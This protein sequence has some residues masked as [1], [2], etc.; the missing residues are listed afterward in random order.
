LRKQF[1]KKLVSQ[2]RVRIRITTLV[3]RSRDIKIK[4]NVEREISFNHLDLARNTFELCLGYTALVWIEYPRE[5]MRRREAPMIGLNPHQ[6]QTPPG[7]STLRVALRCQY[8]NKYGN[9]DR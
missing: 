3:E 6:T 8:K 2:N 9:I 7:F 1:F 5:K 4:K